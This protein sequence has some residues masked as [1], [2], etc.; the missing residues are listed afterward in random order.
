MRTVSGL[1]TIVFVILALII[2]YMTGTRGNFMGIT[3][4]LGEKTSEQV[5]NAQ[6]SVVDIEIVRLAEQNNSGEVGIAT[7]DEENGKVVVNINMVG[8]ARYNT[9]TRPHS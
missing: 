1:V 8:A 7:L 3:E 5:D 6:S 9:P 4:D 2:G